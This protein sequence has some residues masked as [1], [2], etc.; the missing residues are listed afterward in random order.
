MAK[1]EQHS[2]SSALSL[3]LTMQTATIMELIEIVIGKKMVDNSNHSVVIMSHIHQWYSHLSN[4]L[5]MGKTS[6]L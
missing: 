1:K 3:L 2:T 5:Q 4:F 6:Q